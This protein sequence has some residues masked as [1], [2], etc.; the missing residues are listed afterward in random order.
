MEHEEQAEQME[1]DAERM[2]HHSDQLGGRIDD[3]K[4]DW[5]RKEHDPRYLARSPIRTRRRSA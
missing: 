5:E 2:E 3:V 1:D 4:D